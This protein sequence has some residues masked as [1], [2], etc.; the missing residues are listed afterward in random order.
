MT[1]VKLNRIRKLSQT[2]RFPRTF[3]DR[4]ANIDQQLLDRLTARDIANI[5]DGPMEK[6]WAAGEANALR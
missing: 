3:S 1:K 4:L 2:A 5:I 6:S